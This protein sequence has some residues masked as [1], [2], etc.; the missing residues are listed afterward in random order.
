MRKLSGIAVR[1]ALIGA[2]TSGIVAACY[3]QVP[4]PSAPLP[5]TREAQ[6]FGSKPKRIK[7]AI[8]VNPKFGGAQEET[9]PVPPPTTV[10]DAGVD[11]ALELPPIPDA[12]VPLDAPGMG[13]TH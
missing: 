3:D 12:D 9:Q 5:P 8:E 6:P 13:Q 2:A 7:P 11:D 1:I 10:A 4:G